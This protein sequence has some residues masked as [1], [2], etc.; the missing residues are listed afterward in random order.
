MCL[1]FIELLTRREGKIPLVLRGKAPVL[2]AS[3]VLF[4]NIFLRI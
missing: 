4:K 3:V 2:R 1:V